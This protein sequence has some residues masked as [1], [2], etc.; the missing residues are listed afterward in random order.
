ML[1]SGMFFLKLTC[2]T[3]P[4]Y[5]DLSF[6][7]LVR[8]VTIMVCSSGSFLIPLLQIAGVVTLMVWHFSS[9]LFIPHWDTG[10]EPAEAKSAY[11]ATSCNCPPHIIFL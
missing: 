4:C 2:D 9:Y 6:S 3:V 1:P 8:H 11:S 7:V 10:T 5:R